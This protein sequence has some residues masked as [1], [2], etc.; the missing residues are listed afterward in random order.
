M[1]LFFTFKAPAPQKASVYALEWH[2]TLPLLAVSVGDFDMMGSVLIYGE[3]GEQV[4]SID[5]QS[6]DDRFTS[7]ETMAWHPSVK[8]LVTGWKDGGILT[9]DGSLTTP[10]EEVA[11]TH[12]DKQ[13]KVLRWNENGDKLLSA[14]SQGGWTVWKYERK[15]LRQLQRS[16][17]NFDGSLT[18]CTFRCRPGVRKDSADEQGDHRLLL[19]D[20]EEPGLDQAA[21]PA[22]AGFTVANF[23]AHCTWFVGGT[24]GTVWGVDD[25]GCTGLVFNVDNLPLVSLL[26][27]PAKSGV[28][29]MNQVCSVCFYCMRDDSKWFQ[30]ARFRVS[31]GKGAATAS[32][33]MSW[34]GNGLAATIA[35]ENMVRVWMVDANDTYVLRPQT[36]VESIAAQDNILALAYNSQKRTLA[37]GTRAG[38]ILFYQYTGRETSVS[39]D[40]WSLYSEVRL[41]SMV[42][43]VQWGPGDALLASAQTDTVTFLHG[44]SLHRC[45]HKNSVVVQLTADT[46]LY[47]DLGAKTALTTRIS[48][49]RVQG[50]ALAGTH[51]A[52]WNAKQVE[53][54]RVRV[55]EIASV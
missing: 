29:A 36:S 13:V 32:A 2:N 11:T 19:E 25:E 15:Q 16:K 45:L 54:F 39:E 55:Y 48:S 12:K 35:H 34:I 30:Q 52:V 8:F 53:L 26:Y 42:S 18:H 41:D 50:M 31:L 46:L 7:S 3:E 5:C 49:V 43:I 14:D 40:D 47:E 21:A 17:D 27:Y 38:F 20:E 4:G 9:W 37:L 28:I 51:F 44:T 10:P 1:S 6:T 24:S 22:A 23:N 33:Q